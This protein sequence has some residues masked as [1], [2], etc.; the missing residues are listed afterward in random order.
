MPQPYDNSCEM[1]AHV[2]VVQV[3]RLTSKPSLYFTSK[4]LLNGDQRRNSG[5]GY[6]LLLGN[7]PRQLCTRGFNFI[8]DAPH[9]IPNGVNLPR[10]KH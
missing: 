3:L 7:N 6:D 2:A 10:D 5:R 9:S 4:R 8:N 1:G